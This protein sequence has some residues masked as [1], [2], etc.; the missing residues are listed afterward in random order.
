MP[1]LTTL[2]PTPPYDF[3]LLLTILGRYPHPTVDVAHD[4]AYWRALRSGN[5]LALVRVTGRGSVEQPALD[6]EVVAQ[7][8]RVD[9]AALIEA[10]SHV[11]PPGLDRAGF[12]RLAR[13]DARLWGVI[14]RLVGLPEWRSAT[15]FEALAQAI[16]E[17]QIAWAAARRAQ[18]WLVDWAGNWLDH[19][20]RRYYAFPTAG[21]IAAATVETLTP[22]KITFRRMRLLIDLAAQEASGALGLEGLRDLPPEEAY[23]RLVGLKGIGHWT[24]AVTLERAFGYAHWIP[25]N[26]VAL[27]SAANRYLNGG[28]GRMAADEMAAAFGQWGAYG[29]LAARYTLLRW[30]LDEY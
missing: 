30:V 29:G 20:G 8:G 10:V 28:A 7:S 11:L 18:R 14:E 26:D 21:Q 27:Q 4:G 22:L 9:T 17:Q 3:N 13:S 16:I 2:Y 19:A 6:V 25:H 15:V 24:A 23:A 1:L 12:Y 5:G